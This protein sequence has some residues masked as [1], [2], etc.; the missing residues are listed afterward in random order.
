MGKKKVADD[1][2]DDDFDFDEIE[3]HIKYEYPKLLDRIR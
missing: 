1:S 3:G 2:D